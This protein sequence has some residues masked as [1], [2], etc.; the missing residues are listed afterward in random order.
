M[1]VPT[2]A[3]VL[4]RV[5]MDAPGDPLCTRCLSVI[6]GFSPD[7]IQTTTASLLNGGD[8]FERRWSCASCHRNVTAVAYRAKCAHCSRR[9]HEGDKG[10]RMGEE[11]FHTVCLRRLISDESIRLSRELGRRSRRLIKE[12]RRRMRDGHGWPP[13]ESP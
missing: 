6:S 8:E 9:L 2:G 11:V 10:F 3:D 5:L 7:E 1:D 12:S 13:L 4:R